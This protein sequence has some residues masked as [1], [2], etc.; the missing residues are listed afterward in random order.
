MSTNNNFIPFLPVRFNQNN[1]NEGLIKWQA[2][3]PVGKEQQYFPFG[4]RK[5]DEAD[6]YYLPYE[7][8]ID[9]RGGHTIIRR[10]PAKPNGT[11]VGSIKERWNQKDYEITIRG[12]LMGAIMYGDTKQCYPIEDFN[13]LKDYMICGESIKVFCPPLELLG[14][15]EVAVADFSYPFTKGEN[16]Q[17]YE[18]KCYSNLPTDI[19][20]DIVE[21]K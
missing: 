19:L 14:I 2:D 16:V 10:Y 11:V 4:F 12:F 5:L 20:I 1:Q 6:I 7:P 18:I 13:K 9:I 8:V 3:K 21:D 15:H 17:A